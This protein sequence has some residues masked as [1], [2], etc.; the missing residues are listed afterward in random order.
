M[1]ENLSTCSKCGKPA[2]MIHDLDMTAC[3]YAPF[4]KTATL[5]R[6]QRSIDGHSYPTARP[7]PIE[8]KEGVMTI[9]TYSF[10]S[11]PY[12][13]GSAKYRIYERLRRYGHVLNFEIMM[14]LG[15]SRIM[16]GTGRTSEIRR[17]LNSHGVCLD[18]NVLDRDRGVWEYQV[19]RMVQ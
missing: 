14:G 3:C 15:G 17:F 19:K 18:C 10:P 5:P 4:K 8:R 11:N 1:I 12:Q 13:S 9:Q 6:E 2:L 16:N 7:Y